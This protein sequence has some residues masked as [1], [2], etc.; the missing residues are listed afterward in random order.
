MGLISYVVNTWFVGVD[1]TTDKSV[2]SRVFSQGEIITTSNIYF[3]D[4]TLKG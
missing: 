1:K 4:S 3:T 2:G